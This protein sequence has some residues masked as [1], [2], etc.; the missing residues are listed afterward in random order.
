MSKQKRGKV[1]RYL[2][3]IL[4]AWLVAFGWYMV[5]A[6]S[7]RLERAT[8]QTY[9]DAQLEVVRNAAR[10]A[11]VYITRELE[12]RGEQ[13]IPAI[14][15]EV[16]NLFVYPIR[17]GTIGDAWI[18]SPEYVIFDESTDFPPA[19]RGKSMAEIFA[20]QQQRGATHYQTMT[21]AV[22]HGRE[23]AGWYIWEPDKARAYTPWW[24]LFTQDAGRE[25]AAWSP[26]VVFPGTPDERIWVIGL[27]AM[28]PE[29]MHMNG[30]Y[31]YI[32]NLI[33]T[34][35]I[36]TLVLCILLWLLWRSDKALQ[37]SE[38][39]YR[40][41]VEDQTELIA[42]FRPD[43]TLTFVNRAYATYFG[44]NPAAMQGHNFFAFIPLADQA[45]MKAYLAR[46]SAE[47]PIGMAEHRITLPSGEE[48]WQQWTDRAIL[49]AQGRI[50]EF[51][52]VG[53]DITDRVRIETALRE[54]ETRYR[55]VSE[56]VSD[57]AYAVQVASDGTLTP[58]WVTDAFERITGFTPQE[59]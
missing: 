53:R 58:E 52:S 29:L 37:Q 3:T 21:N 19:Y 38:A 33:I 9:Q 57:Y 54:S 13:A 5:F 17:I 11:T 44:T 36:T 46:L 18:Y 10:A 28:L 20:I 51:Q 40:A 23:G 31:T 42:R 39:H 12:Q 2:V 24:E 56:L 49:D 45:P 6:Q 48:R 34:M 8:I 16:F 47:T 59:W 14:E 1:R 55:L 22:M 7:W 26:V 30:S 41:I 25:I 27:S 50:V 32:Q 43:G 4:P 15:Q 35:T